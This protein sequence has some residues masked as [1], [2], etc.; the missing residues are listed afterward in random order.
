MKFYPSDDALV[1][2][3]TAFIGEGLRATER[4]CA[5][6]TLEH[7][8]RFSSL[9]KV[10]GVDVA[11][12][13]KAGQLLFVDAHEALGQ[14]LDGQLPDPQKFEAVVG[15]VLQSLLASGAPVRAYGELVDLL[16][17]D[18][19]QEG[20]LMLESLWTGLQKKYPFSLL[21][22][23]AVAG[24][25]R[26]DVQLDAPLAQRLEL[27]ISRRKEAE[28]RLRDLTAELEERRRNEDALRESERQLQSVTD[29]LP[30]LVLSIDADQCYRYVNATYEEWFGQP[31]TS[32]LGKTMRETL[33]EDAY[34][35]VKPHVKKAL[36]GKIAHFTATLPF[37]GGPPRAIE[38]TYVPRLGPRGH[39]EGFVALVSDVTERLKLEQFRAT[40]S[41]RAS[42]LLKITAA[43]ADAVTKDQVHTAVCDHLAAAVSASNVALWVMNDDGTARLERSVGYQPHQQ[44]A[45]ATL[46][47]E[48][49]KPMPMPV[50]DALKT[51][52]PVWLNSKAELLAAYPKL[53]SLADDHQSYRVACLPLTAHDRVL[54]VLGLTFSQ[55]ESA[56]EDDRSLLLVVS[57]YAAQALERLRLFASEQ[58]ARSAAEQLYRFA[59]ATVTAKRVEEVYEAALEAIGQAL[60]AKRASI[61]T[62]DG[63]ERMHF[64]AWRGLSDEYRAAVDGHSPWSKHTVDPKPVLVSDAW[65]DPSLQKLRPVLDREGVRALA[66]IPLVAGGRLLGK[67]MVYYGEPH[68]FSAAEL[69]L[70]NAIAH[71]LASVT[72][73]FEAIG[74]LQAIV[75][76]HELFAGILA[77]DLRNPLS[78]ILTTAQLL[79][80][81][82]EGE[83]ERVTKPLGR[84]VVS[85][86][87]MARMIEQ[88]L[89]FT[90]SRVGGGIALSTRE[91][92]LG[93]LCGQ[94]VA[95]LELAYPEWNIEQEASGGLLGRFDPDRLLQVFSNLVANACQH[96]GPDSA[97]VLKLDGTR[98]DQVV[99]EVKNQGAV[100]PE[101]LPHLFDPFRGTR[102]RHADK[103]RGLGLGLFITREIVEAHRGTVEVFST[104]DAGTTFKITLPRDDKRP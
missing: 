80:R 47:L 40:T 21:S 37:L 77:H 73:R 56:A 43:I 18:G 51:G 89:D 6:V 20:A 13:L 63:G 29:A 87:R 44:Q 54:G 86:D 75:H 26:K 88:L 83:G 53:A 99:V 69:E 78:A 39:S 17:R 64:R 57:R 84:I 55:S 28:Q 67:F 76:Y 65:A 32:I 68:P 97:V 3:A 70:A 36:A 12:A 24:F 45:L 103:S 11:H 104:E 8:Q 72:E 98:R 4:V 92:D 14:I 91:L 19:K 96:G 102:Y 94:A 81:R 34:A 79:L 52:A 49:E 25:A 23:Y 41:E 100:P 74:R 46:S 30:G 42:R 27:E 10:E 31:P 95:E 35:I 1:A 38:A 82:Q 16:W 66:F 48:G 71:H 61:L 9:L 50:I 59:Q 93:E 7:Q 101:I 90:R 62:F 58:G 60:L 2:A 33:G 22:A 15:P 85:G 5:F